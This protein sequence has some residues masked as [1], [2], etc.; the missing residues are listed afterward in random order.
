[1]DCDHGPGTRVPG[2]SSG[3]LHSGRACMNFLVT[4]PEETG[5]QCIYKLSGESARQAG[6]SRAVS[7]VFMAGGSWRSAK[8]YIPVYLVIKK[9]VRF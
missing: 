2:A 8:L 5:S 3:L 6:D 7:P 4:E 1:M 9:M